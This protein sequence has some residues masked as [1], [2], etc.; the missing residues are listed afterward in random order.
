MGGKLLKALLWGKTKKAAQTQLHRECDG[1]DC[2]FPLTLA[3]SSLSQSSPKAQHS[4]GISLSAAGDAAGVGKFLPQECCLR[5]CNRENR[6][7][8]NLLKK[9][10]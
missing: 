4:L 9:K 10:I 8:H 2:V 7:W 6:R 3:L 1:W 5:K